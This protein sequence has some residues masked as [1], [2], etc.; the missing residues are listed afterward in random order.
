M[1]VSRNKYRSAVD[2]RNWRRDRQTDRILALAVAFITAAIRRLAIALSIMA[3][4][5]FYL[6]TSGT[7]ETFD[8][9]RADFEAAWK[10]FLSRRT[11]ADFQAWRD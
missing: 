7:A 8:E 3:L 5:G 2:D 11:E 4:P 1:R 10:V 6:G 9:A